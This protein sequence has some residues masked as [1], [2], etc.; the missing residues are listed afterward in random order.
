[1]GIVLALAVGYVVGARAG[2][3]DIDQVMQ[4]VRAVRQSEE[5]ADLLAALRSHAGHTLRELASIVE[6]DT[7]VTDVLPEAGDLV[8]KVRHLFGN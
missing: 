7:T 4:S 5:F 6:G 8:E 1:M 3:R 2:S